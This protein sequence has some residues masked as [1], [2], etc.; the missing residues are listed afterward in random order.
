MP[1]AEETLPIARHNDLVIE[2]LPGETVV[3]DLRTHQV[4]CLNPAAVR[5]WELC[6]GSHTR[7]DLAEA[8]QRDFDLPSDEAVVDYALAS[9]QKAALLPAYSLE[10]ERAQVSRRA[11]MRRLTRAAGLAAL[12]PSVRTAYAQSGGF[13][14]SCAV[15]GLCVAGVNDCS[16]CY[17]PTP[18]PDQVLEAQC[19]KR[20][21]W[22][23]RCRVKHQTNCP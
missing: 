13:I 10:T 23:G 18:A 4:H 6:D 16:P 7:K 20:R 15:A 8:L 17:I 12:L 1:R 14:G 22:E 19:D 2:R 5:A 21:C 3:Y 9:L 11:V